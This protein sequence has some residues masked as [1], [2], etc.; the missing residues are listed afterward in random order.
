[1]LFS[2]G[3]LE[4][5]ATLVLAAPTVVL[6]LRGDARYRWMFATL[7][8][9]ILAMVIT[10]ADLLSMLVLFVAFLVVFAFGTRYRITQ[11]SDAR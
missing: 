6:F 2:I 7:V 8:C 11:I 5:F 4:L 10:P 9:A 1:M 3:T